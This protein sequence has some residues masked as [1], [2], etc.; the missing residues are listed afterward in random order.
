MMRLEGNQPLL[1]TCRFCRGLFY[2]DHFCSLAGLRRK[3]DLENNQKTLK[4]VKRNVIMK[5]LWSE[6]WKEF[7][8]SCQAN[9][10]HLERRLEQGRSFF[11]RF[12]N[13]CFLSLALSVQHLLTESKLWQLMSK[14]KMSLNINVNPRIM[15]DYKLK[16]LLGW[17]DYCTVCG[18]CSSHF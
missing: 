1:H 8:K 6:N 14:N 7:V 13:S 9:R 15:Q 17:I 16:K 4:N 10:T 11:L 2:I 3:I 12:S 18:W 5:M